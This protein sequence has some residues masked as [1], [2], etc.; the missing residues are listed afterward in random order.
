MRTERNVACMEYN[1]NAQRFHV[2]KPED[3]RPLGRP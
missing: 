2:E 3:K 1:R